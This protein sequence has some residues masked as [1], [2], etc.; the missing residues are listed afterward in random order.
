MTVKTKYISFRT[1]DF[2]LKIKHLKK[3]IRQ[4]TARELL[5]IIA[6]KAHLKGRG[7]MDPIYAEICN[8]VK[9]KYNL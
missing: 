8:E 9:Q 3:Q 5:S 4:E 7:A 6:V 1:E 2:D